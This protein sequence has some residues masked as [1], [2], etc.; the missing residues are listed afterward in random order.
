MDNVLNIYMQQAHN[1]HIVQLL[2]IALFM[3]TV[4][5]LLAAIRKHKTNSSIGING[6]IRKV[7]ML[8]C[9]F[10]LILVDTVMPVNLIGFIP[11]VLRNAFPGVMQEIHITEFFGILFIG[12]E[13]MSILKNMIRCDLPVKWVWELV[14]KYLNKYT[15]EMQTHIEDTIENTG[16]D[17]K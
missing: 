12:F 3:D 15:E 13:A 8:L 6:I 5:G 4:L 17:G 11:A 10:F 16:E 14:D 9:T 2:V 7:C 1:N